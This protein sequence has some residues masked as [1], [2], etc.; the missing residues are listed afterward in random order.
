MSPLSPIYDALDT[1]QP[2]LALSLLPSALVSSPAEDRPV[3]LALGLLAAVGARDW[4]H[5][6]R[7]GRELGRLVTDNQNECP[8]TG[9]IQDK[10]VNMLIELG[11]GVIEPVVLA[12]KGWGKGNEQTV[13]SN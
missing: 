13:T 7:W 6:G 8:I 3:L 1:S 4:T 10:H 12:W 11:E 9:N 5:A 2:L